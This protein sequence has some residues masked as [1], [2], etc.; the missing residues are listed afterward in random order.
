MDGSQPAVPRRSPPVGG[1]ARGQETRQRIIHAAF[2][3]F[4]E[5]GYVGAS[6]R[7]IAAEAGV[8]PPALQYYFGSKEGLHRACGQFIVDQVMARLEPALIRSRAAL[9]GEPHEA[10]EALC[11]LVERLAVLTVVTAETDGWRGFMGRF[12]TDN[13][14]PAFALVEAGI[15]TPLKTE[16]I[17][18]VAHALAL[19]PETPIA[20]LRALLI[21][22]QLSAL[23]TK[24]DSML[25][26]MGWRDF[27]DENMTLV[28]QVLSDHIRKLTTG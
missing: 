26:V 5:E 6:T 23:H 7:R 4:A 19:D 14:G 8:N 28:K 18:L 11:D 22:S 25:A 9:A 1:Y 24:R 21:M 3:V 13:I 27:S 10:V 17:N 15:A 20:R 2:L 12:E 16:A